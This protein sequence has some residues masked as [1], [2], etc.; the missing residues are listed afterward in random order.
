[1]KKI[2]LSLFVLLGMGAVASA[3][4]KLTVNNNSPQYF[5]AC[6][7]DN[8]WGGTTPP[9]YLDLV[10][11]MVQVRQPV[12]W[13]GTYLTAIANWRGI[14]LRAYPSGIYYF[15]VYFTTVPYAGVASGPGVTAYNITCSVTSPT[16]IFVKIN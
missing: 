10:N 16:D 9:M 11:N 4:I 7:L 1:M 13:N 3:Q 6:L 5:T 2:I 8:T 12:T 14:Y 15:P